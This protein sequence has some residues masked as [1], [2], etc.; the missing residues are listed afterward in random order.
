MV[1]MQ[2]L[3]SRTKDF[4]RF[5]KQEL[6]GIIGAVI[7]TA[8]IFS[9]RDWGIDKFNPLVGFQNFIALLFVAAISIFFRIGCQK[10][11]A[12]SQG[13]RADFKVWWL[14]LGI[15]VVITFLSFGYVPAI[16][17]GSISLAFMVK[18]RLGEFRYGF[19]YT[20]NALTAAWGIL[21]NL[22]AALLFA[23][24]WFFVPES[25]VYSKAVIINLVMAFTSLF[26]LN[27]LDGLHIFFGSRTMYKV[28]IAAVVATWALIFLTIGTGS[29]VFLV[30]GIVIGSLI[31]LWYWLTGSEV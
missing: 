5:Q 27:S 16:F 20:D 3:V 1:S 19:S 10:L 28:I 31:G 8:F 12:L 17:L 30:F 25:Y 9:F 7:V 2:E 22:I 18:Q 23:V 15:S 24:G 26:P 4:F 6:V 29:G 14:G 13:F 11:Y 21:G